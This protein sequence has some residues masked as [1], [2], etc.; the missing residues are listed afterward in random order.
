ML[1]TIQCAECDTKLLGIHLEGEDPT[2]IGS[3]TCPLC[4]GTEF[5]PWTGDEQ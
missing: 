2:P 4:S 3:D 5:V 1:E